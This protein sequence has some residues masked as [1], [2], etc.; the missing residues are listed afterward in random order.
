[1]ILFN[2]PHCGKPLRVKMEA[3]GKRGR[4]PGCNGEMQA[5]GPAPQPPVDS[6]NQLAADVTDQPAFAPQVGH[7]RQKRAHAAA[8]G[9]KA[10]SGL[11]IASL[12][13]GA[14]AAIICWVPLIGILGIPGAVM[15][16]VLG[17][18][19]ILVASIGGKSGIGLPVAG[20]AICVFAL[21]MAMASTGVGVAAIGGAAREAGPSQPTPGPSPVKVEYVSH[22]E[23][24]FGAVL[25]F[26]FTNVGNS[27]ISGLK[28]DILLY[29]QSG[30]LVASLTVSVDTQIAPGASISETNTWML[31]GQRPLELLAEG[32]GAVRAELRVE[33]ISY[34]DASPTPVGPT[35]GDLFSDHAPA[36]RRILAAYVRR[37]A[38]ASGRELTFRLTNATGREITAVKGAIHLYDQFGD[39]VATL[40]VKIDSSIAAGESIDESDTWPTVDARMLEL[41]TE[42]PDSVRIEFLAEQ[43]HFA[44]GTVMRGD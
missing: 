10:P 25:T 3:A 13:L 26:R 43:I 11:G 15:G 35:P 2:C 23:A 21:I 42:D 20:A 12:V 41:L 38:T 1:M 30:E 34:A 37:R 36:E 40:S 39:R 5:P 6:L 27:A 16:L 33:Q 9:G 17:I 22:R 7:V 28:G 29:N 4:C 31:V 8:H 14:L 32:P 24:D 44:D 18:V 19:G